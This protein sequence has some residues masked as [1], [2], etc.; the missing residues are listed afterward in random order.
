[1]HSTA[2]RPLTTITATIDDLPLL[3]ELRVRAMQPSLQAIGRFNP[4]RARERFKKSF[5][6]QNTIK[7]MQEDQLVGF[8]VLLSKEDHLWLDHL[9]IEPKYQG[10]GLGGV[11]LDKLKQVADEANQPL[12]LGALKQSRANDF[13]LK[14]G[15]LKIEE[16]QW[17]NIYQWH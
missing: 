12:R 16:Q 14:Q 5:V 10:V 17:D 15:M 13:Y 8:Y 2:N 1:M 11:I 7:L 9:Y 4:V 3:V 6:A